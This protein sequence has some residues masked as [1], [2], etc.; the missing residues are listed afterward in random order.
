M[1]SN[2]IFKPNI[3]ELKLL[4]YDSNSEI[5]AF[6]VLITNPLDGDESVINTRKVQFMKQLEVDRSE[7]YQDLIDGIANFI[8]LNALD[9][10]TAFTSLDSPVFNSND[11]V[12]LKLPFKNSTKVKIPITSVN[13]IQGLLRLDPSFSKVIDFP[14]EL[15]NFE[16][17][18]RF[19]DVTT[20]YDVFVATAIVRKFL[21]MMTCG[22]IDFSNMLLALINMHTDFNPIDLL[23][24]I[25]YALR[26]FEVHVQSTVPNYSNVV[27]QAAE[28]FIDMEI[29]F[30]DYDSNIDFVSEGENFEIQV[31]I[32]RNSSRTFEPIGQ[33][34][35][36]L[37]GTIKRKNDG[38]FTKITNETK[39]KSVIG[40]KP[41]K[42]RKDNDKQVSVVGYRYVENEDTLYFSHPLITA[43][44]ESLADDEKTNPSKS[45]ESKRNVNEFTVK[46]LTSLN[47]PAPLDFE[48]KKLISKIVLPFIVKPETVKCST[49]TYGWCSEETIKHHFKFVRKD[50][51]F[52]MSDP[53]F[54]ALLPLNYVRVLRLVK[55]DIVHELSQDDF[56]VK[57]LTHKLI[58]AP[59]ADVN[60]FGDMSDLLVAARSKF[61]DCVC[62]KNMATFITSH[63]MNKEMFDTY[64]KA[65][66]SGVSELDFHCGNVDLSNYVPKKKK[67][68]KNLIIDEDDSDSD[69]IRYFNSFND[70][71]YKIFGNQNEHGI[72]FEFNRSKPMVRTKS[73]LESGESIGLSNVIISCI[74]KQLNESSLYHFYPVKNE[75]M[76]VPIINLS[77]DLTTLFS[78]SWYG[79]SL[80]LVDSRIKGH[81]NL[82]YS[83]FAQRLNILVIDQL[84]NKPLK[85]ALVNHDIKNLFEFQMRL[86]H[87][88]EEG[89]NVHEHYKRKIRNAFEIETKRIIKT[90]DAYENNMNLLTFLKRTRGVKLFNSVSACIRRSSQEMSTLEGMCHCDDWRKFG[91]L[92]ITKNPT[93]MSSV[94]S[95]KLEEYS[96][97]P[98]ALRIHGYGYFTFKGSYKCKRCKAYYSTKFESELCGISHVDES[99]NRQFNNQKP[100]TSRNGR[101]GLKRMQLSR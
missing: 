26:D 30:F 65:I 40:R 49:F 34:F 41:L 64:E 83:E 84:E 88:I 9:I 76:F 68:D 21:E 81:N 89:V 50:S 61:G 55:N 60:D 22:T 45:D 99:Q 35:T 32:H 53:I 16:N 51:F 36:N 23:L 94:I 18:D 92:E 14:N 42:N 86:L 2:D 11:Y 54:S 17:L 28:N 52:N 20:K 24:R 70:V 31:G 79:N 73:S 10:V 15:L 38:I 5:E 39:V 12:L 29:N 96:S 43:I 59:C 25:Y 47:I 62:V 100:A 66:K 72:Y 1:D 97:H 85:D 37:I 74:D 3:S 56:Q 67:D 69:G 71:G 57:H 44:F 6:T 7:I 82:S 101:G 93:N 8:E 33:G 87:C 13:Y 63:F 80:G 75:R 78:E 98:C 46:E 4:D 77:G 95:S 90:T 27:K 58:N 91:K 48:D 19:K